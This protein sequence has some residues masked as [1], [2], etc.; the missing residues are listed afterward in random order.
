MKTFSAILESLIPGVRASPF[1]KPEPL[2]GLD[3]NLELRLKQQALEEFWKL[4]SL[5]GHPGL[6][7]PSPMPRLYRSTSKRRVTT[8]FNKVYFLHPGEKPRK[9]PFISPSILEPQVHEKIFRLVHLRLSRREDEPLAAA[10]N[11]VIIRD[12]DR[13]CVL[14]LNTFRLDRAILRKAK[15]LTGWILEQCPEV[16]SVFVLYDPS[17]SEYYLEAGR[18]KTFSGPA[19]TWKGRLRCL[20]GFPELY[21][22]IEGH[23]LRFT[24][25]VFSQI[26]RSILPELIKTCRRMLG[27]EAGIFRNIHLVDL[28]CGYGLLSFGIGSRCGSVTGIELAGPAIE[29]ARQNYARLSVKKDKSI[30]TMRFTEGRITSGMIK[31][32]FQEF[33]KLN[34]DIN[35]I[36]DP[37]RQGTEKGVIRAIAGFH[38]AKILHIFC[39][40]DRIPAETIEWQKAGY[41]PY[42]AVVLDLFPGT[43]NIET[44]TVFSK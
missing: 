2:A 23:R 31:R 19:S 33:H 24:P 34:R 5:P 41:R 7:V 43:A 16:L 40:T 29:S 15:Q 6:I 18:E 21:V 42:Q 38:P 26:N 8:S 14:I 9:S 13:G 3:Y 17:H 25:L 20:A 37:P 22:E 11:W 28:Y 10:L 39:G 35:V 4:N 36:L 27:L 1:S 12:S 32:V 30:P 44:L